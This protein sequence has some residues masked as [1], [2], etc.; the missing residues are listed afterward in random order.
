MNLMIYIECDFSLE[1]GYK[2]VSSGRDT[3]IALTQ[4]DAI[5]SMENVSVDDDGNLQYDMVQIQGG[6]M[7]VS[8][9]K[10]AVWGVSSDNRMWR[11][12]LETLR[13]HAG[14]GTAH[15]FT[16]ID[17]EYDI[18][19]IE[20]GEFGVFGVN[21]SGQ[22]FFRVGTHQ[23]SGSAGTR[24]QGLP[25]L[26]SQISVGMNNVWGVN[27]SNQVYMWDEVNVT[28]NEQGEIGGG[29]IHVS[30]SGTSISTL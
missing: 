2:W 6:L 28:F 17:N 10:G 22:I 5:Y 26:L 30:G 21:A 1:G 25:G 29:W 24:W 20:I 16:E 7:N 23:N 3:A 14:V 27:R 8:V 12:D 9:H 11:A 15:H 19:Q 18:V 13:Q 4:N